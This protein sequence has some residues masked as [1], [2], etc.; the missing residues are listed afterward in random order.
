[1]KIT[2]IDSK[3]VDLITLFEGFEGKPYLCSANVP[4]I[5]FGTTRY[6]N[7]HKVKLSDASISRNLAIE[8]FK[9]DVA[10]FELQVDALATDKLTQNQ[11]SALVSFCYNLGANSLKTSTLLKKVNTNPNDPTIA[12]EFLKWVNAGGR[13]LAGLVRRREAEAS[14]YFKI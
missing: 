14:L 10:F 4:T 11:F 13:K 1:M 8:Y 9:H 5:G 12:V 6:P 3:G 7:G 2:K